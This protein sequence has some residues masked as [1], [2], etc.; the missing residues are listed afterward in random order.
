M[1]DG[2]ISIAQDSGLWSV[3]QAALIERAGI[4]SRINYLQERLYKLSTKYEILSKIN[5]QLNSS[6]LND[7]DTPTIASGGDTSSE[8]VPTQEVVLSDTHSSRKTLTTILLFFLIVS[9]LVVLGWGFF[10]RRLYLENNMPSGRS[11]ANID[12]HATSSVGQSSAK[13]RLSTPTSTSKAASQPHQHSPIPSSPFLRTPIVGITINTT[14]TPTPLPHATPNKNVAQPTR[15]VDLVQ[16]A[17]KNPEQYVVLGSSL[18]DWEA[19]YGRS[20]YIIGGFKYYQNGKYIVS[21]L[22]DKIQHLEIKLAT[23]VGVPEARRSAIAFV[24]RDA[25]KLDARRLVDRDSML[26]AY[27]SDSLL[28]A[29]PV[30]ARTRAPWI[31]VQPGTVY[32]VYRLKGDKVSS[33]VIDAGQIP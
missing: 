16:D 29:F 7:Q 6:L 31:G 14:V 17:D 12:Y 2:V 22:D 21:F 27:H 3:L 19:K 18:E 9:V 24:P 23:P 4:E 15:T 10:Y 28:G 25:T 26:E 11:P 1:V 33:I 32:I 20:E 8:A 5:D 30:S 13:L